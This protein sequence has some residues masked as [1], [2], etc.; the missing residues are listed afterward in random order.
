MEA[1]AAMVKELLSD[2]DLLPVGDVGSVVA[3]SATVR[4]TSSGR[5]NGSIGGHKPSI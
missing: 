5:R 2:N 3:F 1:V 4:E